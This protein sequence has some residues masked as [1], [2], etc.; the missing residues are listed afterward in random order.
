M[1][2]DHKFEIEY[3]GNCAN[4]FDEDQKHY[5][6]AKFMEIIRIG[7]SFDAQ[8]K[9]I[10]DIGGGPSSMLLKC[11][12]LTEGKVCD[13]IDYPE[14]TKLRYAGHNISVNVQPGEAVDEEGWDEVWIYNCLQ[15]V[16]SVE[17]IIN[18]AKRAAPVLRIFEWIDI[19]AHDGHPF[20]L[21]KDMLDSIIA[22][23]G[24][25]TVTLHES[26][27]YGKAYYGVFKQ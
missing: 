21:T 10:L 5:V 3:W 25:G 11:K 23:P 27:C 20:E 8:N 18:N 16:E 14:W 7:Y 15:H 4:T 1:S 17:R 6:Y 12:N 24:S 2:D 22:L 13:P 19:P 26:G 9:R